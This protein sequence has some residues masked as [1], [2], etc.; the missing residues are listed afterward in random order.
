[1]ALVLLLVCLTS[2][3]GGLQD[4]VAADPV[5]EAGLTVA[6]RPIIT[7][8][9][10]FNGADPAGR[11]ARALT[12]LDAADDRGLTGDLVLVPVVVEGQRAIGLRIADLVLLHVAEGDIDS[13]TG[14]GLDEVAGATRDRL[15][16]ALHAQAEQRRL[17]VLLRSLGLSL[18]AS[19]MLALALW[20][21][22]RAT[23]WITN[24]FEQPA[25]PARHGSFLSYASSVLE[26]LC[27]LAGLF[28]SAGLV[29]AWLDF[30]LWMFPGTQPIAV[31]MGGVFINAAGRVLQGAVEAIP[32]LIVVVVI[33]FLAQ[34]LSEASN[35][36]FRA[37]ARRQLTIPR[38][39]PETASA[40][41]R[42]VTMC[43]WA[44]ALVAAYPYLPGSNSDVFKGISVLIGA[45]VTLGS[46]G[47]VNQ[48]MSGL[49]LV[50]SRAL[51]I[52]D[53]VIVGEQEGVV[54]EIGTLATKIVT[55]RNEE[56]T[57]P[58]AVLVG[59]PIRN[60]SK[61]SEAQGTMISTKVTIGYDAPWR[62]VHE[63]LLAAAAATTGIREKPTPFVLQRALSD[64]YVE[65]E[66]FVNVDK[67]IERPHVL[68]ALHGH[69]QDGFAEAGVQ[70]MSPHFMDQP[71]TP[72]L[73]PRAG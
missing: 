63:L 56:I 31:R 67:P 6:N 43:I 21:V 42:L 1:V 27:Q 19:L 59:N 2:G 49:V 13:G 73:P 12:R 55:M 66:L 24:R 22:W 39:H 52:G 33:L 70:I 69:I 20:I 3:A 8:R 50:Y 17:P 30:V 41:R 61:L 32:G 15:T 23:A 11:V 9:V 38:I 18:L 35:A 14:Q 45:M 44:F 5:K 28:I 37:I 25:T 53:Y 68:S 65:Y 16:E 29:F 60:Y 51:R 46:T 54:S 64:F 48:L 7:F 4:A 58:N 10:A 72:V 62:Q 36:I 71:A 26:R 47:I 34:S 40:T 57:I